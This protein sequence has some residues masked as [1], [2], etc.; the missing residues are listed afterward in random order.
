MF[1]RI[2]SLKIFEGIDKEIIDNIIKNCEIR[3]YL[4]GEIIIM[5]HEESNGEGYILKSGNVEII[6]G[7]QRVAELGFGDIF[8]EIALL[9]EENRTATVRALKDCEVLVLNF[10]HLMDLINNGSNLINKTILSRIEENLT[11]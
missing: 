8:G 2:Y 7:G 6:I 1:E 3:K 11:R 4:Q 9:N 10:D 5:E